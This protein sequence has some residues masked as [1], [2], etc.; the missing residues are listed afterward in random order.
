[1][2]NRCIC[3]S[4]LVY[5]QCCE[6]FIDAK[7]QPKTAVELMRSRYSAY[8]LKNGQYMYDTCSKNLQDLSDIEAINNS[9]IEWIGLKVESFSDYEVTFTAF[10]KDNGKIGAIKEHSYF[11][12]ENGCLKYDRGEMLEAKIER[13]EKC[14][15][16][17]GKKFKKC[18]G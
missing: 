16:Q 3:G 12:D 7:E 4:D 13:N 11:I 17:S 18:C 14:P 10:Y 6:K 1:M 5:A 2:K 15:C 9:T 8:A